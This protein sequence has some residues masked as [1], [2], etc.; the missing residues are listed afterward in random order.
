MTRAVSQTKAITV[1]ANCDFAF[2]PWFA[3]T[4]FLYTLL[5]QSA[6]AALLRDRFH[7]PD[8]THAK[9]PLAR[10]LALRAHAIFAWLKPI[11]HTDASIKGLHRVPLLSSSLVF[12]D[13]SCV[14][15]R[16]HDTTF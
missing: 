3:M 15:H 11:N 12:N 13:I 6:Q 14:A 1:K 8:R 7:R 16:M 10:M 5:I 9:V 2:L 4:W